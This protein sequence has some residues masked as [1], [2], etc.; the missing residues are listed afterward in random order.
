M[1]SPEIGE[2]RRAKEF[3]LKGTKRYI[4]HAC[5]G[6]G[7]ERWVEIQ[8]GKPKSHLCEKCGCKLR[9]VTKRGLDGWYSRGQRHITPNGYVLVTLQPED[10]FFLPMIRTRYHIFEHRLVM[11]KRLGRN[12]QS[13]EIVHHKNGDKTDNRIENLELSMNGAHA[14]NHSRG[15]KDG[16][17][18]GL[19]DGR[20]GQIQ[21]LQD[22]ISNLELL[23]E[24]QT[25]QVRFL[26]WIITQKLNVE[27]KED[28]YEEAVRGLSKPRDL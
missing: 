13:W 18:Q 20:D 26:R 21:E 22:R 28:E 10:K 17:K 5:E 1:E 19:Q 16:Y 11:A 12:L 23:L 6:C 25:K 8:K 15:Y 4:W 3:G 9:E 27:S 2:I 14:L 24:E 7:K